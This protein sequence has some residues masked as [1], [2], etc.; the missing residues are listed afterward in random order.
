[1]YREDNGE[2]LDLTGE[3]HWLERLEERDGLK[4]DDPDRLG[5]VGEIDT[6][7]KERL[8]NYE[9]ARLAGRRRVTWSLEQRRQRF[10][11][12]SEGRVLRFSHAPR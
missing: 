1:M 11:P 4:S 2:Q 12:Q 5:R 7:I 8:G 10:V 6:E 3:P 9:S